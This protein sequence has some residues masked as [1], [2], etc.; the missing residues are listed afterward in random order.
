VN[1]NNSVKWRSFIGP[2]Q[3]NKVMSTYVLLILLF[4]FNNILI[5]TIYVNK[6]GITVRLSTTETKTRHS[7]KPLINPIGEYTA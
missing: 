7:Q 6:T 3:V 4:L 5:C 2:K 1:T